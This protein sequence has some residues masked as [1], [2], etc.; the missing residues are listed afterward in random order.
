MA[1]EQ[2]VQAYLDTHKVQTTVEEAINAAVK[3]RDQG[4][5]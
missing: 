3:A 2:D 1:S 5:A 4:V